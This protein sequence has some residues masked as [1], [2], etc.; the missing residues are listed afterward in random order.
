MGDG[1]KGAASDKLNSTMRVLQM[2]HRRFSFPFALD[3][4][5]Y[6]FVDSGV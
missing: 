6:P 3:N 2:G 5:P 4:Q 1:V